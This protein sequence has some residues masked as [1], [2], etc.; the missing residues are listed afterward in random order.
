MQKKYNFECDLCCHAS[1]IMLY[2]I[3]CTFK[4]FFMIALSQCDYKA[5]YNTF[6]FN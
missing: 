1:I 3:I 2:I 4:S 5:T 6:V